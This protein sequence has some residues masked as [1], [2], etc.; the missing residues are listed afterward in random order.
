MPL[1]EDEYSHTL[2]NMSSDNGEAK[3]YR[4]E[5]ST[6]H[7]LNYQVL[8]QTAADQTQMFVATHCRG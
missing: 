3:N 2:Y 4:C 5:D 8:P 1:D 6:R 7:S